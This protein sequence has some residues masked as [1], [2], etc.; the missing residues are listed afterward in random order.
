MNSF[1]ASDQPCRAKPH[2]GLILRLSLTVYDV[3]VMFLWQQTAHAFKGLNCGLKT[4]PGLVEIAAFH[5]S[6][7]DAGM[8]GEQGEQHHLANRGFLASRLG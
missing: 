5:P 4:T 2:A 8:Q 7:M 3:L 6:P 1:C